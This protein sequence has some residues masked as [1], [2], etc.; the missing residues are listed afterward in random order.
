MTAGVNEMLTPECG[1][2]HAEPP[3]NNIANIFRA[4]QVPGINDTDNEGV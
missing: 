3:W 4:I 1:E 2:N